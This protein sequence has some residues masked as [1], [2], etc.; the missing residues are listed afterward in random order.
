MLLVLLAFV[1]ALS[2]WLFSTCVYPGLFGPLR[3]I[4]RL[5][6]DWRFRTYQ[7]LYTEPHPRQ[8]DEWLK[9]TKHEGLVRYDGM[10]GAPRVLVLGPD[11]V[12]EVLVTKAYGGHFERSAL[13]RQ[14]IGTLFGD[15]LL[16]SGG[17][18]HKV[19]LCRWLAL[20]H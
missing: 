9:N 19:C 5:R 1:V 17:E 11:A 10:L 14:R 18:M 20:G 15:G 13:N 6:A 3:H 8:I 16:I 4:P 2:C 7:W 12:K